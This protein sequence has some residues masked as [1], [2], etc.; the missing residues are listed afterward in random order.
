MKWLALIFGL[1]II[2]L[3]TVQ[4]AGSQMAGESTARAIFAVR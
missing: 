1:M 2:G 3:L 4:C